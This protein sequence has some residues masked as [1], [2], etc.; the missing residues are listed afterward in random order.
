VRQSS[1]ESSRVI[2]ENNDKDVDNLSLS[3]SSGSINISNIGLNVL[4]SK[5][6]SQMNITTEDQLGENPSSPLPTNSKRIKIVE[7]IVEDCDSSEDLDEDNHKEKL[8][9]ESDD[10]E[11]SSDIDDND[12]FNNFNNLTDRQFTSKEVALALSLLKSRHSLTNTCITNICKLLKLLRV[13]NCPSNFRHVRSLICNS[14]ETVISGQSF[15]SCPSCNKISSNSY[16]CTSSSTCPSQEK[17]VRNPTIN[18]TLHIEPQI[19]A[20]LERN[21]LIKPN[22]NQ[23]KITDIVDAPLYRKI[24]RAEPNPFVTLLMNSDGAVVKSISRSIWITTFVINELSPSIRFN[25]ENL[26][27]GMVSIGSSK[28]AKEEMQ[29]FLSELVKELIYLEK[30]GLQYHPIKSPSHIEETVRVF[31]IAATCDMPASS[32]MINHTEASGYYGCIHCNI[33]G[34]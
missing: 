25:R 14:Y 22:N 21:Y 12:I 18:H 8:L 34:V 4:E 7:E 19:R 26:I 13:A 9:I 16:H 15:I 2:Q 17:Y 3:I 5:S 10:E 30:E 11:P 27:V 20:I 24:L 1:F 6:S 33:Q 28:P 23:N 31:L 32:L 29:I